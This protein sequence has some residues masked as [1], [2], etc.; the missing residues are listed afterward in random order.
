LYKFFQG[1]GAVGVFAF[2]ALW[3]AG[4]IGWVMNITDIIYSAGGPFTTLLVV[5]IVGIFVFP[6]GA[7][8]GW[9]T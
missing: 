5:R 8:L 9:V 4:I 7:I 6:L 3:I 2:I 1:L